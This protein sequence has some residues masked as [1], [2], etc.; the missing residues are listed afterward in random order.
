MD[1]KGKYVSASGVVKA[2]TFKNGEFV[3]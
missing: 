3:Q 2:G 1:G